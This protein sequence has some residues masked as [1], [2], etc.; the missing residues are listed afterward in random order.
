MSDGKKA[1]ESDKIWACFITS[2][3]YLPGLLTLHYSLVHKHR[4]K[5]PLVALYTPTF[6]QSGLA[7]LAARG[8]PSQPIQPLRPAMP[9]PCPIDPRFLDCWAKLAAFGLTQYARVVQL[10]ADMLVRANMDELMEVPL[11]GGA[12]FAAAPA[13]V[14]NPLRRA[15]YPE[16]WTPSACAY[17]AEARGGGGGG[18]GD[19]TGLGE[20]NSG[21]VVVQPSAAVF[22]EIR[23]YLDR[24]DRTRALPFA[25]QSL[26]GDL[27]RG[28]WAVLPYVYNALKTMRWPGVH[29]ALWR[30]ADVKCVHYIMTPKPWEEKDMEGAEGEEGEDEVKVDEGVAGIRE[31]DDDDDD[32]YSDDR[33]KR[34]VR[35]QKRTREVTHQWWVDVD[36]ERKRWERENG[37]GGDGW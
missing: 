19:G 13:C 37:L 4:S 10:D 21:L 9:H 17:T 7:A 6:P 3:S 29:D 2:L 24:P 8:I 16:S 20:L 15:H 25:D 22:G 30:D 5:Y 34:K 27:F 28:R 33:N 23:A 26:L 18:N 36:L 35:K 32:D 31:D 11:D 12:V 14:C 1:V